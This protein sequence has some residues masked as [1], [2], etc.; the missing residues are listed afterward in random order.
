VVGSGA[1]YETRGVALF[2][3]VNDNLTLVAEYN[4]F[5]IDGHDTSDQN[6][7]TDTLALGAVL[8]W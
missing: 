6:E 7:D 3:D 4:Q 2:H 1:D 8:T 5:S